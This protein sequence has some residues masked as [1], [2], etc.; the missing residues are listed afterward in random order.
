MSQDE[1][2][3]SVM[4]NTFRLWA[5]FCQIKNLPNS[6]FIKHLSD[7]GFIEVAVPVSSQYVEQFAEFMKKQ[8]NFKVGRIDGD[9][10][11]ASLWLG[12]WTHFSVRHHSEL[13]QISPPPAET[14]S[15]RFLRRILN[16]DIRPKQR[17]PR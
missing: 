9:V 8:S 16:G 14:Q 2:V 7:R 12:H 1:G 11:P 17:R 10:L 6:M 13:P 3:F 4:G 5:D 15:E